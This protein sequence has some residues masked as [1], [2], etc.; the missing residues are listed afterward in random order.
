MK[1]LTSGEQLDANDLM[2]IASS[3]AYSNRRAVTKRFHVTPG[4]YVIIPS[5]FEED[6]EAGFLL[7]I[8]SEK[9]LNEFNISCQEENK[10]K[11]GKFFFWRL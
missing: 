3:G 9:P 8:F 11:K 6:I 10:L 5:T 7:R 2:W 4:E 1:C